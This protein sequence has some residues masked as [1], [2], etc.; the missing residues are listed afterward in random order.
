MTQQ[1]SVVVV[2]DAEGYSSF[3]YQ[4]TLLGNDS[5][6]FDQRI[7]ELV[8][9]SLKQI[10][11]S[12]LPRIRD[13]GDGAVLVFEG[14][15]ST[16]HANQFAEALH[17]SARKLATHT[18]S[19]QL[20]KFRIGIARGPVTLAL[21]KPE[22]GYQGWRIGG[23]TV[24]LAARLEKRCKAGQTLI[25]T[26]AW[27]ELPKTEQNKYGRPIEI[28]VSKLSEEVILAYPR[29]QFFETTRQLLLPTPKNKITGLE[30]ELDQ[31]SSAWENERT[32]I[33]AISGISGIG[34]TTLIYRWLQ[35]LQNVEDSQI[36]IWPFREG[37][38]IQRSVESFLR[39]ALSYFSSENREIFDSVRPGGPEPL[40]GSIERR[41]RLVHM[42]RQRK[43]LLI[44]DGIEVLQRPDGSFKDSGMRDFLREMA[45]GN[46]GL[47]VITSRLPPIEL[48]GS[49]PG[50]E[51]SDMRLSGLCTED[52]VALLR[53]LGLKGQDEDLSKIVALVEGHTESVAFIGSSLKMSVPHGENWEQALQTFVRKRI[54]DG[55]HQAMFQSY[56][57]TL[58][59][60]TEGRLLRILSLFEGPA[61]LS[62]LEALTKGPPIP[63]LT[64]GLQDADYIR[65][66]IASLERAD[67]VF[68][69]GT[70]EELI[71][72]RYPLRDPIAKQL[73]VKNP[74][75]WREGHSR[76]FDFLSSST[77][78][79]PETREA[80][81]PLYACL[82]HARFCGSLEKALSGIYRSRIQRGR[83][84]NWKSLGDYSDNLTALEHFFDEPWKQPHKTL[85]HRSS[86][87]LHEAGVTLQLL[88]RL[89]ESADALLS[90]AELDDGK[91]TAQSLA[92]ASGAK[93]AL[94]ELREASD[95]ARKAVDLSDDSGHPVGRIVHR[96]LMGNIE[97]YRGNPSQAEKCFQSAE[98]LLEEGRYLYS[99]S[100]Y[101]CCEYLLDTATPLDGSAVS[102]DELR[103]EDLSGK[104][105]IC[106]GV[107]K[108][109]SLN[110]LD[111]ENHARGPLDDALGQLAKGRAH[112]GLAL[113]RYAGK[114]IQ[115]DHIAR[116]TTCLNSSIQRLESIEVVLYRPQCLITKAMLYRLKN[117]H[118]K[119]EVLLL[120]TERLV[121]KHS[122]S[123]AKCDVFLEKSRLSLAQGNYPRAKER[124]R[125]A[126]DLI[127]ELKYHRRN[128]EL[129]ALAN[130]LV[131]IS[132]GTGYGLN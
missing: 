125:T 55:I 28:L 132:K 35:K 61:D 14:P 128:R 46:A 113:A 81:V 103:Q 68:R 32:R 13:T 2:V 60:G 86:W 45:I 62:T 31:L 107:L 24:L 38:Q 78:R 63:G 17:E 72:F 102:Y 104:I 117:E 64:D 130:R 42:L 75:A 111:H 93:L 56:E 120:E 5:S 89:R 53:A 20:P 90:S 122:M 4:Q 15:S 123:I 65:E 121:E 95:L 25:S 29:P 40:G 69:T 71:D 85:T 118:A 1:E 100:G 96:A 49:W 77:P 83:G 50:Q 76:L 27:T 114:P 18:P 127:N 131:A 79:Y 112:F 37:S 101:R 16:N 33:I 51:V 21:H 41:S 30:K 119:A 44:I 108:R 7:Q 106:Q 98:R 48:V 70:D 109:S 74:E 129:E 54:S 57:Q 115:E 3:V 87:L 97:L 26:S 43:T 6:E 110:Q 99:I 47:V 59:D 9:E 105:S 116:A 94:G 67:W 73:Q 126:S 22:S 19:I 66:A 34:K 84:Y 92:E 88:G 8:T 80:L 82:R 52:G 91:E 10:G 36:F 23:S 58:G 11:V 12:P 124:Y 39:A